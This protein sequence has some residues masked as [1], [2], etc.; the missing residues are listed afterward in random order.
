[1]SVARRVLASSA[2]TPIEVLALLALADSADS[3]GYA[4]IT[5]EEMANITRL[6]RSTCK[7]AVAALRERGLV[8]V[9][10]RGRGRGNPSLYRVLI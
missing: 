6:S 9:A 8:E 1:M 5:F 7:R 3:G 2:G 10:Q 4:A